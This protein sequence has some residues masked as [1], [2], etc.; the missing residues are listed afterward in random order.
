MAITRP[1]VNGDAS[2][3]APLVLLFGPQST[4]FTE[5]RLLEL[6]ESIVGNTSLIFLVDAIRELPSL[7]PTLQQACAHL[8]KV[9]GAEQLN[10]LCRFFEVGTLPNVT[11]LNNILLAPLT[12]IS[13]IVEFL[14]LD[15]EAVGTA[16]PNLFEED[17]GLGDVQGFCVGFLVAAAVAC[18]RDRTEFQHNS[19]IAL[20]LAVCIGSI[21]DRD[22]GI[23]LNQL[24]RSCSFAVRWKT[25]LEQ[26]HFESTLSSYPSVSCH[27]F[28]HR[29]VSLGP[30]IVETADGFWYLQTSG[31]KERPL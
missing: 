11:G 6:R 8:N 9:P 13:Q 3:N 26:A 12:V 31:S 27:T 23:F 19:A 25:E 10:Q 17:S 21:V 16:F 29:R 2:M 5:E 4:H 24:D 30:F 28:S 1:T 18:S 7:W 22:E 14:R 15:E 20:R